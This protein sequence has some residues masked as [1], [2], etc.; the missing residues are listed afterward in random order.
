MTVKGID[1]SH[2]NNVLNFNDVKAAGYDFAI[3]KAGGSDKG[4]YQDHCFNDYYR[5]A[6][7]A[8]LH[9]GAYYFVG[10]NFISALDGLEDAKRFLRMLYEKQFDYPIFLDLE[11]T[12]PQEKG[13]ATE[14]AAAFCDY[15]ESHGYYVGIYASDISG[16]KERLDVEKLQAYDKWVARYGK[17]PEYVKNY[18]IWQK[19]SKGEVPGIIGPIDIDISTKDYPSIIKKNHLNG[20]R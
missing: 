5:L 6:Q 15:L 4:F 12:P 8:G 10:R 13:G 2:W 1:I 7:L 17:K 9:V 3:I 14:A 18:G 16:F 11:I 20:W 19:S